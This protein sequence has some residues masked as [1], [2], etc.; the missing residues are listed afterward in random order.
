VFTARGGGAFQLK[1]AGNGL[2]VDVAG[3]STAPGG[4]VQQET[5]TGA[6]SQ[7]WVL[8]NVGS[9]YYY[10]KNRNS[11]L[12]LDNAG[13]SFDPGTNVHQWTRNELAPEIWKLERR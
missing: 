3:G 7:D 4:N 6:A 12:Y 9:G 1:N 8:E 10:L 11:G 13:G 2:C 5:C